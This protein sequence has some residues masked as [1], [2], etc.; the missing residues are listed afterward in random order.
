MIYKIC[1]LLEM[2]LKN[3]T[4]IF[5]CLKMASMKWNFHIFSKVQYSKPTRNFAVKIFTSKMNWDELV[6][7]LT[8]S[9][10]RRTGAFENDILTL[11]AFKKHHE[12]TLK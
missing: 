3:N 9:L 4:A 5:S 2:R 10:N 12:Q 7:L 8:V 11:Q 1:I 6:Y